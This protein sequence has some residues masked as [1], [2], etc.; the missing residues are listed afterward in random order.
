MMFGIIACG[1]IRELEVQLIVHG[2]VQLEGADI[3]LDYQGRLVR[4]FQRHQDMSATSSH[5]SQ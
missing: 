4:P 2:R 5:V 1:Y 3:E